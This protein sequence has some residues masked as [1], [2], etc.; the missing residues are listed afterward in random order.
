MA[1]FVFLRNSN[2]CIFLFNSL[3]PYLFTV[4]ND[5][6]MQEDGSIISNRVLFSPWGLNSKVHFIFQLNAKYKSHVARY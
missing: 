1:I 5:R 2:N 6:T 3:S 4:N